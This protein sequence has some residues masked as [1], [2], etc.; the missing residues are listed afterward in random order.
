MREAKRT[1]VGK[2]FVRDFSPLR[3]VFVLG[4]WERE[5]KFK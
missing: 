4:D 2:S 3:Q 5:V 1:K